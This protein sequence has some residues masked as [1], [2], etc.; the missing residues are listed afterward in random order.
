MATKQAA[1]G[2]DVGQCAL[3]A[4]KLQAAGDKVEILA[5]EVIEHDKILSHPEVDVPSMIRA[6]LEKLV[7]KHDMKGDLVAVAVPGQQTLSRF[8]KL[9]PVEMKKIPDIVR[10]EAGQ[11]IPF[12]MDEVVWDYQTFTEPDSPDV[13]VGIFAIRKELIRAHI[14]FFTGVGIEPMLAQAAPLALYNAV[15]FDRPSNEKATILL[16]IGAQATDLIVMERN[17]IWSRPV[18]IGGNAFTEAL[19]KGFRLSHAKAEQLKRT[20][21]TTQHARPIFQAMRPVFADLISEVQ[22]SIGFYT[23]TH[24]ESQIARI[25]GVGNAFRLPGLQKFMQQNLQIEVDRLSSFAR[26]TMG[27]GANAAE[28]SEAAASMPVALGLAVQALG[29][30][31]ITSN[32]LPPEI[33]K[34]IVWR[35]KRPYF[36][37]AAAC[38]LGSAGVVWIGN[39]RAWS[40]VNSSLGE[41]AAPTAADVAAAERLLTRS[42][43]GEPPLTYANGVMNALDKFGQEY[44]Q[45]EEEATRQIDATRM[46][47]TLGRY[48]AI[49]PRIFQAIHV[50]I[51]RHMQSVPDARSTE[52]YLTAIEE[53]RR[54]RD[55]LLKS[56]VAATDPRVKALNQ[57]V[58]RAERKEIWIESFNMTYEGNVDQF[59]GTWPEITDS[60]I[61]EISG[62]SGWQIEVRGRTTNPEP[63]GWIE[64]QVIPA[65]EAEGRKPKMGFYIVKSRLRT[66]VPIRGAEESDEFDSGRTG[67]GLGRGGDGRMGGFG[68]PRGGRPG[69]FG[70][71]TPPPT[72][73]G[74]PQADSEKRYRLPAGHDPTTGEKYL[75][76]D[77]R[78]LIDLLVIRSDTPARFLPKTEG[79]AGEGAAAGEPATTPPPAP[80]RD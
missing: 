62:A 68:A 4:I 55:E 27:P 56:G 21:A 25:L 11:Q 15:R 34:Q 67:G 42:P 30:G 57:I 20:A 44:R 58:E 63:A 79:A 1:W 41:A 60:E 69:G 10:F 7:A 5:Y 13:E 35:K 50:G 14:D 32:L 43:E 23:A 24:R 71:G 12:D 72:F 18:P 31:A 33:V 39:S 29:Q 3:K 45:V 40:A 52:D 76:N 28:F 19:V 53:A 47:N 17:S 54:A 77:A 16:D 8:T 61:N 59:A 80:R 9:P 64:D 51:A 37:A 74:P 66:V 73:G 46:F 6:A 2:I 26:A 22:R 38:L 36:T 78:F 49:L 75:G 65:I 70:P 48:N